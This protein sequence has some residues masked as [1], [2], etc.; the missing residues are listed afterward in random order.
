MTSRM[1]DERVVD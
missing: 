1:R